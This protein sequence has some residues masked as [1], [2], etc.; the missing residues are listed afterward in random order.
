MPQNEEIAH[1]LNKRIF[2]IKFHIPE[3]F[4]RNQQQ[5]NQTCIILYHP[6][7]MCEKLKF[8]E[9]SKLIKIIVNV[10]QQDPSPSSLTS[11]PTHKLYTEPNMY[12]Y[13]W[14]EN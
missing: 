12:E 6:H 5:P 11:E 9:V 8:W 13:I 2:Q 7:F 14:S 1:V 3:N 10:V 4:L